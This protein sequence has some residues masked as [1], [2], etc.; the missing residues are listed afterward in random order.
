MDING[1][2]DIIIIIYNPHKS[3]S[4]HL[5]LPGL[6]AIIHNSSLD[7][8][9]SSQNH[10]SEAPESL[11]QLH[12]SRCYSLPGNALSTLAGPERQQGR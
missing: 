2:N 4:I 7:H 12:A 3:T 8:T 6:P 5:S 9:L 11:M 1:Y 10:R